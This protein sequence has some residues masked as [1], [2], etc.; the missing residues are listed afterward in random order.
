MPVESGHPRSVTFAAQMGLTP[1]PAHPGRYAVDVSPEWNCPTVPQGGIMAALAARAMQAELDGDA[2]RRNGDAGGAR[3]DGFRLRTLTTVFAAPVP[4]GPVE[5]DV[6]VLRRGRSMSQ[7]RADVRTPGAGIGHS[8]VAVFGRTRAGFEFTDA[9]MPEA[10][11][12]HECPSFRDAGIEDFRPDRPEF[13]F[14]DRVEGR[15]ALG[16]APW[17]DWVPTTSECATWFR[18]EAPPLRPDGSLDPLALVTLCDTMPGAVG[19]RMGPGTPWWLPPSTDLTVHVLAEAR[20][21]WLLAQYR[22]HHA[23]GGYASA[24]VHLWDPAVGL[25]ALGT[26]VMYLVFPEGPPTGDQRLPADQRSGR[27]DQTRAHHSGESPAQPEGSEPQAHDR[28][29]GESHGHGHDQTQSRA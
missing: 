21:E 14:W 29:Q 26:Q 25:V 13:P 11:P 5:I 1:D 8:S 17:D 10:P 12:P 9:T 15:P 19:E 23:G 20:S 18:F 16:H 24:T 3:D 27:H 22:A 4:A 2:A 6:T 28:R 7:L